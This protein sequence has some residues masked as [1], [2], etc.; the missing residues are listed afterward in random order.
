MIFKPANGNDIRFDLANGKLD[1]LLIRNLSIT[2]PTGDQKLLIALDVD[3]NQGKSD[4]FNVSGTTTGSLKF[5]ADHFELN[6]INDGSADKFQLISS[7]NPNFIKFA[8]CK[9]KP[10]IVT[11]CWFK[12]QV[13]II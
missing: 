13:N 12:N 10:D 4:F 1:N 2:E 9:V 6:I 5:D 3:L 11:V 8:V 7:S